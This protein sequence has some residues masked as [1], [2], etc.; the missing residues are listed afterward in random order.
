VQSD[1]PW[2]ELKKPDAP[3][4]FG[5]CEV[6]NPPRPKEKW[7]YDTER[8][9]WHRESE[10]GVSRAFAKALRAAPKVFEFW[11]D[12]PARTLS[13]NIFP[14]VAGHHAANQ[15]V[16]GRNVRDHVSVSYRLSDIPQQKD[17]IVKPFSVKNSDDEAPTNVALQSP[18]C[19]S[20]LDRTGFDRAHHHTTARSH[21]KTPFSFS[22]QIV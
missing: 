4:R 2:I 12:G 6:T 11:V 17:P 1:S 5:Y 9:S 10:P 13:V 21:N 18:V 16:D 7:V 3:T 8:K 14:E 20:L 15:L 22:A 19:T